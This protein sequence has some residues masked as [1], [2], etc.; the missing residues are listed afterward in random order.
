MAKSMQPG[1]TKSSPLDKA[2][3]DKGLWIDKLSKKPLGGHPRGQKWAKEGGSIDR[4]ARFPNAIDITHGAKVDLF[5]AV[6]WNRHKGA[7]ACTEGD[8]HETIG[9]EV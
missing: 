2:P 9:C 1:A 5:L 4:A 6:A 7:Q 8:A 3:N